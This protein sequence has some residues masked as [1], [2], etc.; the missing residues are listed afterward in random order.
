MAAVPGALRPRQDHLAGHHLAVGR[1][2]QVAHEVD[3][4]GGQVQLAA[5]LAGGVVVGE[6]MV[7]IVEAL[8]CRKSKERIEV[9]SG[10][11]TWPLKP[12]YLILPYTLQVTNPSVLVCYRSTLS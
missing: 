2:A 12:E 8:A 1:Q 7:V 3:E 6:G 9:G 11:S 10:K 4:A 5:E